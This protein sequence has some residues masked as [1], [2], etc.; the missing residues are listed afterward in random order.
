MDH[1]GAVKV[2]RFR[3]LPAGI[4]PALVAAILPKCPLCFMAYAGILGIFGIDPFLYSFWI[5]PATICFS[6]FTLIVLFFQAR[7]N[8]KYLPFFTGMA[9]VAFI[10]L[11]KFYLDSNP[12]IYAAIAALLASSVWL[13]IPKG[14]REKDHDCNC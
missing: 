8:N 11:G 10:L 3:L 13:S 2:K 12:V 7:R 6:T 9:A 4:L 14:H 5:L 1:T